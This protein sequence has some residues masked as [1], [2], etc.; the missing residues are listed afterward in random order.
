MG[1][2]DRLKKMMYNPMR[3]F[4]ER[5]FLLQIIIAEVVVGL[6]LIGDILLKEDMIEVAVLAGSLVFSPVIAYI[7]LQKHLLKLGSIIIVISVIF[8]IL[9]VAFIRG[10]G[11]YGGA[12]IWFSFSYLYI[13]LLLSGMWR[14]VMLILL[15]LMAIGEYYIGYNHPEWIE[16]HDTKMFYLDSLV[17]VLLVGFVIY[18]MV[19]FVTKIYVDENRRAM[20]ETRKVDSLRLAQN[21]FFSNMSHEIRTPINT[22]I[23]LNEMILRED[24]SDEVAEDAANVQS[25]SKMLLHLINDILDMSKLDSGQMQLTPVNYNPGSMLSELVGMLWIRAKEKNLDFKVNVSPE[26]P[27]GL[28]GDEV[29]IKQILIN[30]VNNAIKYTR[31]GTVSLSIQCGEKKGNE[32]KIIYTISDTGVGIKKENIP[33]LFTAFKRVDETNNRHIEGTGLG[34]SI[35]KQLVDLMGGSI[36]VN[37]VYMRGSTFI[38]EIPQ[39]VSGDAVIGNIDIEERHEHY[40]KNEY[41]QK[42]EAPEARILV[43]DDNASNLMVACK[44]LRDTRVQIDTVGNG[45]DALKKTL[46]N[47][48]HVILMDH[49]MPEMDGITCHRLIRSQVG[50]RCRESKIVVLTANADAQSRALYEN[51]RFDGYLTKPISGAELE[52]ELCRLL[53]KDLVYMFG[54]DDEILEETI[55]WM[56]SDQKKENIAVTTESVADLPKELLDEY[57]ISVLAHSVSTDEGVFKD[58]V[59]IET[60]GLLNYMKDLSHKISSLA[61]DVKEHEKFFADCLQNANNIIHVS[62]SSK[63]TGSGC[64]NATEAAAA[65]D[66]VS[67]VDTGHLSS[68]QGIMAIEAARLAAR[69]KSVPEICEELEK[70][71]SRVNTSFVVDN[72]DFL[73]RTHQVTKRVASLT[74]SFMARPVLVLKHGKMGV[75]DVYF[76][77][78]E[79]AWKAYIDHTLMHVGNIDDEMLFVTYVGLTTHE[80][81]KI[82]K[83]TESRMKFKHIYFQKASPGIAL[84]CGPGT[85]GLLFKRKA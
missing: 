85:F 57:G 60:D 7:S 42:F 62:I 72:L 51:E 29:R 83:M 59:E 69:Q 47:H 18:I 17:S 73:A 10:G 50:G 36:T 8:V 82:K 49:L 79:R 70:L 34:L 52:A 38:I 67:V 4:Q 80:L 14:K 32:V 43:V 39:Q 55:S 16:P 45:A 68:G 77:S 75:G 74:K 11:L 63:I 2:W 84:N 56:R 9:P 20:E 5:V 37:S 40:K 41:R 22:I 71:K 64:M 12:V 44:L 25:A 28:I 26:L 66:N 76:G 3:D 46:S 23:G 61:P 58:G 19:W 27:S 1:K 48:Y 81:E 78:R 35:V 15:S 21:R 65:F 24:I 54:S 30:V 31:E 13:G 6:V 53:P 33:Y